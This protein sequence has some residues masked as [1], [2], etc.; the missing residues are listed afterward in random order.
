MNTLIPVLRVLADGRF[1]SGEELGA[2]LGVGRAAVWKRIGKT[3]DY[4]IE[5]HAVSGK[6]YRLP[7]PLELLDSEAIGVELAAVGA[8]RLR[9]LEIHDCI[10]STNSHLLRRARE[11]APGGVVCLAE[12]QTNGRGRRDRTW[13]STFGSNIYL[14]L[15]WRYAAGPASLSGLSLAVGVAVARALEDLGV[16]GMMLKWP[17]DVLWGGRKLG[18]ILIE[19]AGEGP[20]PCFVVVG[21]GVNVHVPATAGADIDQP[22]IDLREICGDRSV[23]RNR[24][25]ARMIG[26]ILEV[27]DGFETTGLEPYRISWSRLDAYAGRPVTIHMPDGEISGIAKGVDRDGA[28][29]L[30]HAGE[31]RRYTAGEV[32]L[33]REGPC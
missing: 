9:N 5:V 24:L 17:N 11:G 2:H 21:I 25:A 26:R 23:S 6:G 12:M 27:L 19:V 7:E 1:H 18:G 28:L 10:D 31:I 30:A 16:S 20:G 22:W 4:G 33:H 15:L 29:L 3:K 32:T 14:S 8:L 13:V